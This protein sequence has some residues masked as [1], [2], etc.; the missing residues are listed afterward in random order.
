[1]P[2]LNQ[3]NIL[4]N[5]TRDPDVRVLS[6]GTSCCDLRMAVNESYRNKA[7]EKKQDTV[8][9][10][11]TAWGKQA[12]A[13]G[14]YLAKGRLVLIEGKLKFDTW[15]KDGK[16]QSKLTVTAQRIHFMGGREE[17][18][19]QEREPAPA[20]GPAQQ[21]AEIPPPVVEGDAE[22]EENLPF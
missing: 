2:S 19:S 3:V 5:L 6:S 16:K 11:V 12:E 21:A 13:C 22:E 14:K 18:E 7:G 9:V 10:T 17:E 15:E 4:G 1:M 20:A 8:F